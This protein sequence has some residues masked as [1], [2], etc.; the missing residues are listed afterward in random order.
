MS[1]KP[2]HIRSNYAIN[3]GRHNNHSSSSRPTYFL[4]KSIHPVLDG[5][6]EIRRHNRLQNGRKRNHNH[7]SKKPIHREWSST[8]LRS[9]S[10]FINNKNGFDDAN[11]KDDSMEIDEN[12]D[13]ATTTNKV[14]TEEID[15]NDDNVS[16][17]EQEQEEIDEAATEV[18]TLD[19]YIPRKPTY[20][21]AN[22]IPFAELCR[23]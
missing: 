18:P 12:V 19:T 10:E 15:R 3:N 8:I 9:N 7:T 6:G 14:K 22:A 13:N 4:Q 2:E 16:D 5:V 23:R 20:H 21:V 1:S 11:L 17:D